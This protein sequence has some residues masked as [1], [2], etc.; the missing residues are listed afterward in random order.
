VLTQY[1]KTLHL[2]ELNP[3]LTTRGTEP[4]A[5]CQYRPTS[6]T[7]VTIRF[8]SAALTLEGME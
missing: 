6:F 1:E 5:T 4:F 8:K 7:T 2:L 3:F